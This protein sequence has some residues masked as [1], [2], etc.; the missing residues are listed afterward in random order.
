MSGQVDVIGYYIN[1]ILEGDVG[2]NGFDVQG[3]EGT[4]RSDGT[5]YFPK[6]V[7]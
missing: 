3:S 1:S 5:D 4:C 7:S 6:F 2:E